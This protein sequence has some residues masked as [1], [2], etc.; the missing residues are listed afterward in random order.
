[1]ELKNL[2]V[3]QILGNNLTNPI[4]AKAD[5]KRKGKFIVVDGQRRIL[6]HKINRLKMNTQL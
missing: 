1:M 2:Q 4:I 3:N 5:P 6:A